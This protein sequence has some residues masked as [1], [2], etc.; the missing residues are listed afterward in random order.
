[1]GGLGA[2]TVGEG[3]QEMKDKAAEKADDMAEALAETAEK[4]RQTIRETM[5]AAAQMAKEATPD[6]DDVKAVGQDALG[7]A[8]N[9]EQ[10]GKE[11][12]GDAIGKVKDMAGDAMNSA[13]EKVEKMKSYAGMAGNTA[14]QMAGEAMAETPKGYGHDMEREAGEPHGNKKRKTDYGEQERV[15][16]M[17]LDGFVAREEDAKRDAEETFVT[18]KG[19]MKRAMEQQMEAGKELKDR[20]MDRISSEAQHAQET[21][22]HVGDAVRHG[23]NVKYGA[24]ELLNK[25]RHMGD[26][27]REKI[28]DKAKDIGEKGMGVTDTPRE[29]G[30]GVY[31]S[32]G[33]MSHQTAQYMKVGG[34]GP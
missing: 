6:V 12:A 1:M 25:A 31:G 16:K 26:E 20:M 8:E 10:K 11:M 21:M 17:M 19:D 14:K 32:M 3:M 29:H 30:E 28:L 22:G 27:A 18:L 7:A 15:D 23:L 4:A 5:A 34:G 2:A 33:K 24:E 9:V 13:G